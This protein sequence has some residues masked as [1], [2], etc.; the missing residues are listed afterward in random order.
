MWVAAD[1]KLAKKTKK[2]LGEEDAV[3]SLKRSR[4]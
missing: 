4:L 2:A 3:L 1:K